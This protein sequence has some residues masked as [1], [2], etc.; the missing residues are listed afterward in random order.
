MKK[1]LSILFLTSLTAGCGV[2]SGS[3]V[4]DYG[5]WGQYQDFASFCE[6]REDM[7]M[8]GALAGG[9]GY[10]SGSYLGYAQ[11]IAQ[12]WYFDK[13]LKGFESE[14]DQND[15]IRFKNDWVDYVRTNCP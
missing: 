9:G 6:S 12:G 14:K 5:R 15:A 2:D 1:L 11:N 10:G 7:L 8:L 13:R 3:K 4:P